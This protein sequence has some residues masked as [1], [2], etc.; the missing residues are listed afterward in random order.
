MI[1]LDNTCQVCGRESTSLHDYA[2][3]HDFPVKGED[4]AERICSPC[5]EWAIDNMVEQQLREGE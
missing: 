3:W 5:D 4:T 2:I 1:Y